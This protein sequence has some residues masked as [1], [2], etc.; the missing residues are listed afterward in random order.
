MLNRGR[1]GPAAA[2][3]SLDCAENRQIVG[4]GS[5]AG[6]NDGGCRSIDQCR[7]VGPRLLYKTARP[8]P[9]KMDGGGIP[10]GLPERNS[11][12]AWPREDES[13]S[14]H[15]GRNRSSFLQTAFLKSRIIRK[16]AVF[17]VRN[18]FELAVRAVPHFLVPTERLAILPICLRKA[19]YLRQ[20]DSIQSASV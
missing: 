13:V 1:D 2:R 18:D 15:Y 3:C 20:R 16:H 9:G 14:R 6:K 4:F 12:I 10:L 5:A 11:I 19:D 17:L 7:D 8:L